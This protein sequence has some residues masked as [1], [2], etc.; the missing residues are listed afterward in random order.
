MTS[1]IV[2]RLLYAVPILIGV[3]AITFALFF[4]VNPPE[5]MARR[6]L[7]EK[8]VTPA[9][10]Q[11]WLADR[12]YDVPLFVNPNAKGA[13]RLVETVFFRKSLTLLW[14][15]FGTSDRNNVSI[16]GQIRERM[17][18]SLTITVPMMI[19]SLLL[20]MS[21]AL[22]VAWARGTYLDTGAVIVC[23][24]AM[25]VSALFYIVGGQWIVSRVLH[26]APISGYDTGLHALK[27]LWLPVLIG[28]VRGAGG[29]IRFYR[30]VFLEEMGKD[31]VRTARAKGA[32]EARVLFRH[33]LRNA[34]IPVLTGVV[35]EIPFLFMGSLLLET[36]FAIPGLGS[37]LIDA[38]QAQDFAIVR[39]E[40]YLG[41]VLYV[42][43]LILT[44]VSYTIADPRVR[45]S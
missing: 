21:G 30:T 14:L 8:N 4:V 9:Q 36:F 29:D 44:D 33:V 25:S 19:L 3:N 7:G 32:S 20:Y 2:R 27:F 41:S 45:L 37:F 6:I 12:G 18:P 42:L 40:V 38:I 35:T 16:G 34:L 1:Y 23:V 5:R 31:Y 15:D 28:I 22:L 13:G 43:G 24:V 39:A 26:L 11:A 10:V 17:W